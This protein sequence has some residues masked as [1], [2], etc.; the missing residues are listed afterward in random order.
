MADW[1]AVGIGGAVVV[2]AVT[3]GGVVPDLRGAAWVGVLA[4]LAAGALGGA[5]AGT[6]AGGSRRRR[7][8]HGLA[9][10]VVGGI[11]VGTVLWYT[12]AM[13]GTPEGVF[14]GVSYLVATGGVLSPTTAARYDT[15][16]PV[17]LAGASLPVFAVVGALAG[18]TMRVEDARR[19]KR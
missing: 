3:V 15:V 11:A 9:S 1:R 6:L 14:Y 19:S 16:I 18:G 12:V 8:A 17:V 10:G 2:C 7:T 13:P 4:L 5:V